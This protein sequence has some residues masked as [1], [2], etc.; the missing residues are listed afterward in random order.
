[1]KAAASLGW[2]PAPTFKASL[3]GRY[4]GRY[5]DYTPPR[6]IGNFW[7]LDAALEFWISRMFG[8]TTPSNEGLRL[9][10][11][12]TNLA[13]KAPPYS[14]YFRGYDVYNYDIVGRTIFARLQLQL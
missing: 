13:D 3:A 1:M 9:F 12:G 6:T 10:I 2:A 8:M 5:T 4:T 7:Y 11:T 14:T